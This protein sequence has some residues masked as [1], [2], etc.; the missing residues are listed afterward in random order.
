MG[1]VNDVVVF[2]P[3]RRFSAIANSSPK[4]QKKADM[5]TVAEQLRQARE[6]RNLTVH[7]VAEITKIRTDHLRALEEGNFDVFS[8]PVYIRGFVRTLSTLLKL[9]VAQMMALLDRELK[10]TEKFSEPPPLSNEPRGVVDFVMLQLSKVSWNRNLIAT[11]AAAIVVL[12]IG[13]VFIARR[14]GGSDPLADLKPGVYQPAQSNSADTL[15]LPA[16]RR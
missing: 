8:A 9:D 4:P 13:I 5:S 6:A 2:A 16:P 14:T 11:V 3:C 1:I 12:I 15:P 7:Q 10:G